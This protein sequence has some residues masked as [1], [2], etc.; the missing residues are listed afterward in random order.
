M[1]NISEI[2]LWCFFIF[3]GIQILQYL[4]L[5]LKFVLRKE[6]AIHEIEK[7]VSVIIAARN[8]YNNLKKFL[9]LVLNQ[10]GV[11]FEVI[12][13]DDCSFDNTE[14]LLRGWSEKDSRLRYSVVK[15][16]KRFEGGK[17]FAITMGIKA[18]RYENLIFIDAD[19][20]PASDEWLKEMASSLLKRNIVLGYGAYER[21]NSLLNF[22]IRFDTFSIAINYLSFANVGI[23]YMGVG[24]NMAYKSFLFFENKGF[25]N[26]RDLKSGDDD[27]FINEV[28]T[29][30]NTSI[31]FSKK[32]FTYSIPEKSWGAW[33]NQ[34]KRH[35]TTAKRYK[36]IHQILLF[37]LPSSLYLF[38]GSF[39]ALLILQYELQ[40]VLSIFLSRFI[41]QQLVYFL[42]LKKTGELELF[43]VGV[44]FDL[45]YMIFYPAVVIVNVIEKCNEWKR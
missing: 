31:R 33:V 45:F 28:G 11:D 25:A 35:I 36:V 17:K 30:N 5:Y 42:G 44:V 4:F 26:H 19:C 32:S 18:A 34:K 3:S 27:L 13:I 2:F 15:E 24:R 43:A 39:F 23:P 7:P 16:N 38:Y 6:E 1:G 41:I 22:F 29:K 20:Y 37:I 14:D 8:E 10:K 21:E 40:I 9:P 12:V